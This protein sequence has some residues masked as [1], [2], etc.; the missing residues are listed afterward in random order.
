MK[1]SGRIVANAP[2]PIDLVAGVIAAMFQPF[3]IFT[4]PGRKDLEWG[5]S[6]NSFSGGDS[7]LYEVRK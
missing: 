3:R 4:E 7:I 2:G 1:I 5:R 6:R